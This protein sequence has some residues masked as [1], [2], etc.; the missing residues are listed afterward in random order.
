M[1]AKRMDDSIRKRCRRKAGIPTLSYPQSLP[2]AKKKEEIVD[3]IRRHQVVIITGETGSGKTTQIPKMCLE[4]G[5]GIDGVIGHTQPRRVAAVAVAHRIAEELGEGI[6]RSV[7][8][9]IRFEEKT[10]SNPYIK[11]MTDGI[12]LVEIRNDPYLNNYDTLIVDEAHERSLNIDFALGMIKNLLKKRRDLKLIITSATIDT[13]KFSRA[14]GNAPI[15]EVSGRTYPVEVSYQPIDADSDGDGVAYIDAA[16]KAVDELMKDRD[17][18]DI[19]IFMPTERDIRETCELLESRNYVETTILPM[20]ARLSW[21]EQRRVFSP[22][23]GRKIVVATNVAETSITIA[24]I[25]YVIDTGLARI[26]LYSPGSRTS[27]LPVR[28]ISKSSADQ[29]KGRCGRVQDGICIRLYSEEDYENRPLFTPPEILRSNLAEVILRM[30]ALN[31]DDI[32]LFPFI[33]PPDK[34][35]IK[36]GLDTLKELGAVRPVIID[37]EPGTGKKKARGGQRSMGKRFVLTERGR[38]MARIPVDPRISRMLIEAKREGCVAEVAVIASALSIQDPRERPVEQEAHAD[39]MHAHFKD[40]DSDFIALLNIWNRYHETWDSLRTQNGLKRFCKG[41]FLSYRRMREWEDIHDEITAIIEE[42]SK[43]GIFERQSAHMDDSLSLYS[44]IH[45]SILSGYLSNIA[46]KK[47][48]NIYTAAKGREV[49]IFPG[50]CLFGRGGGWIVAAEMV[51]TSRLFARTVANID[52][53]WLE[54]LGGDLCRYTYSEPYWARG[55]GEVVAFEQVS[56][57]GLIIVRKRPVSYGRINP[58]EA[59][60]IFIRSAL[61]EGDMDESFTFLSHNRR[62]IEEISGMEDKLRRRDILVGENV[63]FQ[64]YEKRLSGVYDVRTLKKTI[65][66]RGGEDFLKMKEEDILRYRPDDDEIS[67]YPDEIVVNGHKFKCSY[68]FDPGRPD[69]GVTL[70]IPATLAAIPTGSTDWVVAGLLREKITMLIKGLPKELRRK[71]VP[72]PKTV[73]IIMS[74]MERDEGS[75]I[76]ALGEFIYK[77]FGI[78][79]PASAW[80]PEALPDYLKLRLSIVDPKGRE[81]CSGRDAGLLRKDISQEVE[82]PGFEKARSALERKGLT[83]WDF[84]DLPESIVLEEKDD[85]EIHAYPALDEE[86]GTVNLRLFRKRED[87]LKAHLRGVKALCEIHFKKDL[88][89]LKRLLTLQ[90][91]MK[92]LAS[93]FGGAKYLEDALYSRVISSLFQRNIRTEKEFF[94]LVESAG[95]KIFLKGQEALGEIQPVLK[96]Y[97]DTRTTLRRL[98]TANQY[99][100]AVSAFLAELR[101]DL[102][103]LMPRRFPE[104]YETERL[105]HMVRYLKALAIRAERGISHPEK[106]RTRALEAKVFSD[107]L[108]DFLKNLPDWASDEKRRMI[109]EFFWTVEEYK[110]SL[111]AQELKTPFS[112]SR[113]RLEEKIREIERTV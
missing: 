87:A 102:D 105:K 58:D 33:D 4:A 83:R 12:L 106:D 24:G 72:L 60:G 41:H 19:L 108:E 39:Y 67:L 43:N 65:M 107:Q 113:K 5:R 32:S 103:R 76:S 15:I 20:F 55:R 75:I 68:R 95:P 110:V 31:I 82:L 112:I 42:E 18:G 92:K 104:L 53:D 73:D 109:D 23:H 46:T 88:K 99:S 101:K 80:S 25:R 3:A 50:S 97:H 48:K 61:V 71:L 70:T 45:R 16:V 13:E 17:R 81:L 11:I 111:F 40:P 21:T 93:Y 49:M 94:N 89:F 37:H 90:G 34:R 56:L 44:R 85:L 47:E 9:K 51:Q 59:S 7:G 8:Y 14:F 100:G 62:L 36:D 38:M 77:R 84:G 54:E 74:E 63:L 29:R 91:D 1:L 2:V 26:S 30:L 22:A 35:S 96:A 28:A 52:S 86:N 64:F 69:D 79:I 10:G 98:E 66:D 78:N 6:G 57:F 27:S